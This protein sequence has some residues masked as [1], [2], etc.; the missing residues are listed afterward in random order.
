MTAIWVVPLV[1][2]VI[3]GVLGIG[4][5][6]LIFRLQGIRGAR[7]ARH[8]AKSVAVSRML[9]VL[10][11]AIKMQILPPV[12]RR[13]RNPDASVLL[14]LSRLTLDLPEEDI[15]VALWAA[16]QVQRM[17]YERAGKRYL[18]RATKLQSRLVSWYRGEASVQWFNDALKEEPFQADWKP[19]A[20]VRVKTELRDVAETLGLVVAGATA[21]A[22]I[23]DSLAPAASDLVRGQFAA[24]KK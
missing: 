21:W 22:A 10:D 9:D 14:A 2:S 24:A 8:E 15:P 3:G 23:R 5:S 6:L 16:S 4:A 18:Q 13:F 20:S 12:I 19:S 7:E 1:A 17:A 11:D